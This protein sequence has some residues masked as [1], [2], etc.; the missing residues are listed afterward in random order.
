MRKGLA[1]DD[2]CGDSNGSLI[3]SEEGDA[4]SQCIMQSETEMGLGGTGAFSLDGYEIV[5][6]LSVICIRSAGMKVDSLWE[7]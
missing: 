3:G 2:L 4:Y 1:S 5:V 6:T 7:T